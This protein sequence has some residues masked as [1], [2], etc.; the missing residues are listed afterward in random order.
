MRDS[1]SENHPGI[2]WG[3]D[4]KNRL[5]G[6][7]KPRVQLGDQRARRIRKPVLYPTELRALDE[8]LA[9]LS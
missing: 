1:L 9:G 2:G 5:L 6:I 8:I 3:R 7:R 4:G